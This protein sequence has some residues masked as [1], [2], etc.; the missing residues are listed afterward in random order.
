MVNKTKLSQKK[1]AS[2]NVET[3]NQQEIPIQP[4]PSTD[5]TAGYE[6]IT[7]KRKFGP[8]DKDKRIINRIKVVEM[9][10]KN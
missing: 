5:I 6:K 10:T 7:R 8:L 2:L 3:V 9:A 4:E 1:G